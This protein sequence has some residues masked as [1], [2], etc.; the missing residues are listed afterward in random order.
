MPRYYIE[1][2]HEADKS[3]C[4]KAIKV[5]MET[6]SHF[7]TNAEYGCMDGDHTA[8]II[9]DL[10]SKEQALMIVPRA[11]RENTK[12]VQLSTFDLQKVN[13]LLEGH[14]D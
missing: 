5:L 8:R 12:V 6:G 3:A 4:L 7:M 10:D 14:S 11:Y 2:P 1:V 13:G 9:V